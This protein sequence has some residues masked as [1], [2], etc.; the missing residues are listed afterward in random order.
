MELQ[1]MLVKCLNVPRPDPE[2]PAM[3]PPP[4]VLPLDPNGASTWSF[5]MP[6]IAVCLILVGLSIIIRTFTR[7][8]VLKVFALEDA[9]MLLATL[10]FVAFAAIVLDSAS[11]GFGKHQW[12]VTVA[13]VLRALHRAYAVQIIYCLAMYLAKLGVLLQLKATFDSKTRDF[14]FWMY[15]VCIVTFT[16][17][18]TANLFIWIFP[19]IPIRKKWDPFIPGHCNTT[20]KPGLLSGV[21]NLVT[22]I[23]ILVLP[24]YAVSRLHMSWRKKVSICGIFASGLL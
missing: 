13:N 18:Y 23:L 4:G 9:V 10:G 21:V 14:M 7:S 16:C 2:C 1:D 20:I 17:A 15:W 6:V 19:C 8:Y 24:I 22:D 12:N 3:M 5:G 11:L